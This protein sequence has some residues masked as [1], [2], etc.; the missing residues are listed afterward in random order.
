MRTS[1]AAQAEWRIRAAN[2][3]GEGVG[4]AVLQEGF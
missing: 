2:A 3:A 4:G 1:V